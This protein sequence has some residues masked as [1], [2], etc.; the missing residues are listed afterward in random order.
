[1]LKIESKK[2]IFDSIEVS[3]V[4]LESFLKR[5]K[6]KRCQRPAITQLYLEVL[7]TRTLYLPKG[8]R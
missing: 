4:Q 3:Q 1:M 8:L 5:L 6:A 2:S 7:C